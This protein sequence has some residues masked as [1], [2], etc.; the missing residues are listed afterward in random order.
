M[1]RYEEAEAK[2]C[3]RIAYIEAVEREWWEAW[4]PQV[5]NQLVPYQ[6]KASTKAEYVLRVGDVC[7]LYYNVKMGKDRYCICR[8][9]R[10]IGAEDSPLRKVEVERRLRNKREQSLPY[11]A[12]ELVSQIV[13]IQRL[14]R[15]P[16][17]TEGSS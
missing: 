14:V 1:G 3:G 13:S 4:Y 5:F 2:Y 10:L 11:K 8:V 6:R 12:K 17:W 16:I 9:S 15:L 7:L